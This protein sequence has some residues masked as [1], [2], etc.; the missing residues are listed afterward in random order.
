MS[1]TAANNSELLPLPTSIDISLAPALGYVMLRPGNS[2]DRMSTRPLECGNCTCVF[3]YNKDERIKTMLYRCP[4]GV[5]HHIDVVRCVWCEC[6][7]CAYDLVS[8]AP[9]PGDDDPDYAEWS[10][11]SARQGSLVANDGT[12]IAFRIVDRTGH[13]DDAR[14]HQSSSVAPTQHERKRLRGNN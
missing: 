14:S 1:S 6:L 5:I 13:V 2:A 4:R 8:R 9:I 11:A 12:G 10:E 3:H 7:V